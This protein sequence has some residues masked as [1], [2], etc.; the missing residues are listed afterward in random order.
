LPT[1]NQ[2]LLNGD[3]LEKNIVDSAI[4]AG[5]RKEVEKRVSEFDPTS[6]QDNT[7][8]Q[9]DAMGFFDLTHREVNFCDKCYLYTGMFLSCAFGAALPATFI[10]FSKLIDNLGGSA[11]SEEAILANTEANARASETG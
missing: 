10:V 11:T 5:L 9:G 2:K 4:V 6:Q 3:D 7:E 1:T 8:F